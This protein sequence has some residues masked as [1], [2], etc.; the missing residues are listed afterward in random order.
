MSLLQ[1]HRKAAPPA[2]PDMLKLRMGP[3]T[4]ASYLRFPV[5]PFGTPVDLAPAVTKIFI[6]LEAH[7]LLTIQLAT[8][9][10]YC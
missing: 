2:H 1:T 9:I 8:I 6:S 7:V 4:L 3:L 10:V 5:V